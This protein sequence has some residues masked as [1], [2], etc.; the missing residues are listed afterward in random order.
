MS[1]RARHKRLQGARPNNGMHPTG[2]SVNV[3]RK[4]ECRSQSFPAGDAGRYAAGLS[5]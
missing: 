5:L 4:V 3:M 1:G 2:R